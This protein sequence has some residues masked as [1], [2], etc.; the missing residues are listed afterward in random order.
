MA[1]THRGVVKCLHT[2][3]ETPEFSST[4]SAFL[5][6]SEVEEIISEVAANPEGGVSLGGGLR[7]MRVGTSGRGK[8]RG[9][10]VVFLF[11]GQHMPVFLLAAFAKNAKVNLS[12]SERQALVKV[13]KDI[14]T[15][16]GR[17]KR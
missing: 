8:R 16:Y 6:R 7:K 10:R 14:V 12:E 13:A 9:G 11:G 5:S 4:A 17:Q 2:V 15:Q 3:V 1:Y